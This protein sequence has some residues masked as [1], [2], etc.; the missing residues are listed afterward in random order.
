MKLLLAFTLCLVACLLCNCGQA[1]SDQVISDDLVEYV[2]LFKSETGI[3][4]HNTDIFLSMFPKS[5]IRNGLCYPA[6]GVN[7]LNISIEAWQESNKEQLIAH[8]LGHCVL[9]LEHNDLLLQDNCPAS[10]MHPVNISLDCWNRYKTMYYQELIDKYN[11]TG[12]F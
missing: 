10:I 11:K 7:S 12:G 4:F 2:D 3:E 1:P 6:I 8:E 9:G 5:S